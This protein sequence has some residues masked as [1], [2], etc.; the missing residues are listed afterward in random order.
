MRPETQAVQVG[1]GRD[2]WTGAIAVPV[3]RS[4]TF[5]HPGYGMST[6]FD[7]SRLGNPTRQALEEAMAAV[8][9]GSRAFAFASGMA[10]IAALAG[11]FAPGDELVASEDI[12]GHSYR[13]FQ[14]LW[15]QHGVRVRFADLSR[16]GAVAAAV[17]PAT[18]AVFVETPTNPLLR[19]TDLREAAEAAHRVGALLVVDN[20]FLTWYLQRPLDLGADVVVYSASKYL[21]GHNDVLAGLVVVKDEELA[22]RLA[23]IQ[24]L[25]GAVLSPDD[26]W[27]VL[28]GM[29]TL[30]LRME[31]HA[32]NAAAI[33]TWLSGHPLVDA[34]HYPGL[35]GQPGHE[36]TGRQVRGWGGMVSFSVRRVRLVDQVLSRLRVIAF[37]ESLGG[38]ESLITYPATQTHRDVPPDV[39]LRLGI[40]DRLLRLSVGVEHVDDLIADLD[41]ALAG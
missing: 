24:I 11:L 36:L 29:K 40:T 13:L 38:V 17:S 15:A 18:R 19:V 10:A 7:Y 5:L 26:A 25:T 30:P 6:G 2:P 9:G 3:Y 34:V 35:P 39:R 33:A 16:P 1:V 41:Q 23:E 4:A 8:E 37:A 28:R 14:R 31:R 12:Y 21:A 22:A 20:T 27:L 32:E